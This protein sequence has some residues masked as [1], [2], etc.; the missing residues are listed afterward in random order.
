[1][2][3]GLSLV[4]VTLLG[5]VG[6]ASD[7]AHLKPPKH[8]EECNLPLEDPRFSQPPKYPDATL[9][10][11]PNKLKSADGGAPPTGGFRGPGGRFNGTGGY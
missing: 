11:D 1:M 6:C 5:L 8:P 3:N 7:D 2:W 4:A 10:T 9:N